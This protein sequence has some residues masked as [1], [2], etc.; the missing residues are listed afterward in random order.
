MATPIMKVY[1]VFKEEG[2][3]GIDISSVQ[4]FEE[5]RDAIAYSIALE[6][7]KDYHKDY[8]TVQIL[9]KEII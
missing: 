9:L 7:H 6:T 2:I 3:D 8:H 5:E 1:L 4:V